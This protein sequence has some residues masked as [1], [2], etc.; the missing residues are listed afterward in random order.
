MFSQSADIQGKTMKKDRFL[1]FNIITFLFLFFFMG[2]NLNGCSPDKSEQNASPAK[3]LR[4]GIGKYSSDFSGLLFLAEIEGFFKEQRLDIT[5]VHMA[6]GAAAIRALPQ[7]SVDMSIGTEFPFVKEIIQG[8]NLKVIT[9]I[10]R[11]DVL[12]IVGRKDRGIQKP[13]DLRGKKIAFTVGTQQE[14]FLGRYLLYHGLSLQDIIVFNTKP[15]LLTDRVVSGK[16]DGAVLP[17]PALAMA[18]G[19]LGGNIIYW[20]VQ[21]EQPT[22][23]LIA[24]KSEFLNS[25][26]DIIKKFL[27]ALRD[28]ELYYL[29][30]PQKARTQILGYPARKDSFYKDDLPLM[31]YG[32]FLDKPFLVMMEDEA[33][34]LIE[35]EESYTRDVP[36]FLKFIYFDGLESVK[37]E[38][39]SI[40]R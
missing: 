13:S 27:G 39:I 38:G 1:I 5:L 17:E 16:A 29:E 3:K 24:C 37:P 9:T 25:H 34:W 21:Y 2:F 12:Y 6:S 30:N 4:I 14:F 32:L 26:S 31:S 22:Y 10:W 20:S 7:G 33:R 18:R 23:G 11:G 36:N 40:I 35:K 19:E 8:R 28:A 15:M